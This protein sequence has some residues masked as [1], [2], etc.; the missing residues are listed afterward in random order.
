[1]YISP[2]HPS[3]PR[4]AEPPPDNGERLATFDRGDEELRVTLAEFNGNPYIALRVWRADRFGQWWPVKGKGCSI[5]VGELA[6]LIDSLINAW[7]MLNAPD[8]AAEEPRPEPP[9]S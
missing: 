4:A 5:R 9:Q 6:E 2:N 7:N 1:M 3:P 8:H